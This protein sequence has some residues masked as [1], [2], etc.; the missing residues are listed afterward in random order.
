MKKNVLKA[1]GAT[2][3]ILTLIAFKANTM[4]KKK[5]NVNESK[6]EW[7]GE[8]L[9]G[10]HEGTI[11]LKDGYFMMDGDKITGGKFV[12]DMTSI[13]VTDLSGESKGKLE[14]HLNSDDFFGVKNYPEATLE[15]KNAA[16]KGNVYGISGELTIKGKT[17]PVN[18][19]LTM[20][21]NSATT[22]LTI[23]RTKYG[24]RYG[25]GSFFDNLGDNTIYDEFELDITLKF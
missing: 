10:S 14:G 9:T 13:N 24:I 1:L 17:K 25:S 22:S 7:T 8:K 16:K 15:I 12:M 5:V 4:E 23:D 19:D 11:Q 18:F 2:T 20:N 3:L 21:S 6:I